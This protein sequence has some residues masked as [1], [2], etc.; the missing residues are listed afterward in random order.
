MSNSCEHYGILDHR[1]G[2]EVCTHCALVL[3]SN[4]SFDEVHF[5][6]KNLSKDVKSNEAHKMLVD[7]VDNAPIFIRTVGDKLNICSETIENSIENFEKLLQKDEKMKNSGVVHH[8]KICNNLNIA[9]YAIYYTLKHEGNPRPL[10]DIC[11]AAGIGT[12]NDIWK[13]EKH[14]TKYN[15]IYFTRSNQAKNLTAKD[16]LYGYYSYLDMD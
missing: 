13:L 10:K 9:T 3:S 5:N 8:R 12:M 2:T 16:L 6:G 14:F 1:T 7:L 15:Q 4:L 11:S